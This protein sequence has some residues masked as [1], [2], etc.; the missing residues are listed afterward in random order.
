M[1]TT[2]AL[3]GTLALVMASGLPEN[4][5]QAADPPD[6]Q[7][8]LWLIAPT[9]K[10]PWIMRIDNEGSVGL[11]IPADVRLLQIE[12]TSENPKVKPVKCELPKGMR[13]AS[14]PETR[15]LLLAPGASYVEHFDPHLFCF[16]KN[17]D[18]LKGG[19]IV[20]ARFGWETPK[21]APKKK[22]AEGPFAVESVERDPSV[23]PLHELLAPSIVLS[24]DE[25]QK[26]AP[27]AEKPAGKPK[28]QP[29]VDERAGRLAVKSGSFVDASSSRA[30]TI[31]VTASN[32]GKRPITVALRPWMLS[33]Q[34]EDPWG[35]ATTCSG[36]DPRGSLPRDAFK[37]LNPDG[38][39]AFTLL[40]GEICPRGTFERPGLYR[41]TPSLN[42]GETSPD[43]EAFTAKVKAE[44]PTLVRLASGAEPFYPDAP[45]ALPPADAVNENEEER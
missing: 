9:T 43:V 27:S 8:R 5:A 36:Q 33:F 44:Q 35:N 23:A 39:S 1:R 16:G 12:I 15:A 25:P 40:L 42:A 2:P 26:A 11:R 38:S 6:A 14:F 7:A 3:L 41:V 10:G 13:P 45:K 21:K 29:I 19:A 32:P 28:T 17:A 18:A 24:H 37:T 20:R 30:I 31:T 34:V 22:S 4:P